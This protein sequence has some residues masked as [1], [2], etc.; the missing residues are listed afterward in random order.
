MFNTLK[1][2][3]QNL[4]KNGYTKYPARTLYTELYQ[5]GVKD[6]KGKRYFINFYQ[7]AVPADYSED[8][9]FTL[10]LQ[11]QTEIDGKELSLNINSTQWFSNDKKYKENF[12]PE[13]KEIEKFVEK[14]WQGLGANYYEKFN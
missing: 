9:F 7:K 1:K 6:K 2:F 12:N 4:L 13:L 14:I 11:L 3:K 8:L 5:K 10:D